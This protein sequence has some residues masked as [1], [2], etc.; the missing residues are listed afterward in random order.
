MQT[1]E[2]KKQ[3]DRHTLTHTDRRTYTLVKTPSVRDLNKAD[4]VELKGGMRRRVGQNKFFLLC[5]PKKNPSHCTLYSSRD[6]ILTGEQ[7]ESGKKEL[8]K[9]MTPALA[10]NHPV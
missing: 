6:V 3:L 1:N 4:E 2:G 10:D 7:N 8:Q 9:M 5:R